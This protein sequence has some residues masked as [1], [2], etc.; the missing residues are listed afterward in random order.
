M[1]LASAYFLS[2]TPQGLGGHL[3]SRF[4]YGGGPKIGIDWLAASF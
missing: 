1:S 4:P 2:T 3:E